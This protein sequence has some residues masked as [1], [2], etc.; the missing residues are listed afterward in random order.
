MNDDD[1][2]KAAIGLEMAEYEIGEFKSEKEKQNK[3]AV[4]FSSTKSIKKI[5]D[6][7]KYTGETINKIKALVDAPPNIKTPEFLGKWAT[8]SAKRCRL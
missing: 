3:I 4:S 8:K 7:G 1:I 2:R 6:E 5:L